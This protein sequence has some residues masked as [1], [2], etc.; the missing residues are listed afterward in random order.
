[1]TEHNQRILRIAVFYTG[2]AAIVDYFLARTPIIGWLT[3][4]FVFVFFAALIVD[5]VV[6]LLASEG[7]AAGK[8]LHRPVDDLERLEEIIERALVQGQSESL[9]VLENRLRS[10]ALT[11]HDYR[12]NRFGRQLDQPIKDALTTQL[13]TG[14]SSVLKNHDSREI[15]ALLTEIEAWLS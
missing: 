3:L 9:K 10:L 15:E 6:R 4:G 1:M 11:A 14:S 8:I 5:S 12:A 7:L 13:L 2:A